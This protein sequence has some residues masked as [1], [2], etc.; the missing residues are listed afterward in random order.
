MLSFMGFNCFVIVLL[1]LQP[2][3]LYI[4]LITDFKGQLIRM[5]YNVW[6][7]YMKRGTEVSDIIRTGGRQQ[8]KERSLGQGQPLLTGIGPVL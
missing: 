6:L 5:T 4:S 2:G 3:I 8:E 7:L 1:S